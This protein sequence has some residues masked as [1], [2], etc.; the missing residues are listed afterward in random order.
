M[1][2]PWRPIVSD[3][4]GIP[5]GKMVKDEVQTILNLAETSE[6][7]RRWPIARPVDDCQAHR[8]QPRQA[9]QP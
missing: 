3:W 2:N 6:Q 4:T 9:R 7:A 5:V 1:S 8:N